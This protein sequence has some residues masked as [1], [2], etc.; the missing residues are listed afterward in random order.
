MG[1]AY[2]CQKLKFK[3]RILFS[4]FFFLFY[5]SPPPPP[6]SFDRYHRLIDLL[7][8]IQ[9]IKWN[10]PKFIISSTILYRIET[11]YTRTGMYVA[12][13]SHTPTELKYVQCNI[14]DTPNISSSTFPLSS[15]QRDS[16]NSPE[17]KTIQYLL[18]SSRDKN[19]DH[20]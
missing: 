15:P 4:F 20:D 18:L 7:L 11:C 2:F 1:A 12:Y 19:P 13:G 5:Y 3:K 17:D 14:A 10:P 16:N 6:P 9:G 8:S